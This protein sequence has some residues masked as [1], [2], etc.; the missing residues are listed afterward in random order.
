MALVQL[1]TPIIHP[2]LGELYH[3]ESHTSNSQLAKPHLTRGSRPPGR[4]RGKFTPPTESD[5]AEPSPLPANQS[6][7]PAGR[8]HPLCSGESTL[9]P[10]AP[11]LLLSE[12]THSPHS[13]AA[14]SL[15]HW[16]TLPKM[17]ICVARR[18]R[19]FPW[20]G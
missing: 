2:L 6:Q 5:L 18:Q 4:G 20:L 16:R 9:G 8:D 13:A 10:S 15:V 19:G 12:P 17:V 14:F 7:S 11:A 1:H 3:V